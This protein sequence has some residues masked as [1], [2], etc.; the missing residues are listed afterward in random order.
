MARAAAGAARRRPAQV[1]DLVVALPRGRGA[2][3]LRGRRRRRRRRAGA[4]VHAGRDGRGVVLVD[5]VPH[6][7][8]TVVGAGAERAA[9]GRRPVDAVDRAR[10]ALELE[11]G[12]ARLSDVE[13]ADD[14]RV[15]GEGREEVRVMGRCCASCQ[16]P[17]ARRV[18]G[19]ENRTYPRYGEEEAAIR[20]AREGWT[21]W[22]YQGSSLCFGQQSSVDQL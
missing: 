17:H 18:H 9:S 14:V 3:L 1:R 22:C 19:Q 4:G 11:Q 13:D 21:G 2:A 7:H 8:E 5:Q 6:Q 20:V 12:L 10:V 15:L 16:Y